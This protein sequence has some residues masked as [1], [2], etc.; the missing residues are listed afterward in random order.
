VPESP[1]WDAAL[2]ESAG[3]EHFEREILVALQP[4]GAFRGS[5]DALSQQIQSAPAHWRWWIRRHPAAS[6]S[7]ESEYL[8]LTGLQARNVMVHESSQVPLPVLLKRMSVVVSQFSGAAVEAAYLG[9]PAIFLSEEACGQFSR[10]IEQ[11]LATIVPVEKLIEAL[12][13]LPPERSASRVPEQPALD[14][15][16]MELQQFG[17]EYAQLLVASTN[18]DR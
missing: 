5:W 7:Q 2:S 13:G 16:L 6:I 3:A 1:R 9:I 10:L 4:I 18:L 12:A 15:S 8:S 11:G 14:A 17:R